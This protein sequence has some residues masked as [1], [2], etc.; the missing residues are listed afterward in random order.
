MKEIDKILSEIKN[1]KGNPDIEEI[2]KAL[3]KAYNLALDKAAKNAKTIREGYTE[4][5]KESILKLKL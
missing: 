1:L 4:V 5:D 3:I 2:K